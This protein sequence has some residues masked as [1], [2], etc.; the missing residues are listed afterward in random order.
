MILFQTDTSV[1][2]VLWDIALSLFII[3]IAF[4]YFLL[5]FVSGCIIAFFRLSTL[6]PLYLLTQPQAELVTLPIWLVTIALWARFVIVTYEIPRVRGFR[7]AVG[8]VALLFML[9]AELLGG[10][11]L[12]EKGY[13]PWVWETDVSAASAG[14]AVLLLFG[15]MPFLLMY[16]EKKTTG[17]KETYHGHEKKAVVDAV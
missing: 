4:F 8:F 7:L 16:L 11:V 2:E 17:V 3:R 12:Y 10:L 14:A 9:A 1:F 13:T 5:S 15:L 6:Q